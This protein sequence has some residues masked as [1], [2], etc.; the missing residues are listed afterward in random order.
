[1]HPT[2]DRQNLETRCTVCDRN[3]QTPF[4][5]MQYLTERHDEIS[6]KRCMLGYD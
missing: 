3:T 5:V 1:M 4:V 6:Q 2:Q